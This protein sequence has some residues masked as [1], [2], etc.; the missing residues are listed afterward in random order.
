MAI[1]AK[2]Y[3]HDPSALELDGEARR[4]LGRYLRN[5]ETDPPTGAAIRDGEATAGQKSSRF[6]FLGDMYLREQEGGE[7]QF[8]RVSGECVMFKFQGI[9]YWIYTWMP[10]QT[11]ENADAMNLVAA[12]FK[13]I[14]GRVGLLGDRAEWKQQGQRRTVFAGKSADYQLVDRMGRWQV[15]ANED[16][17]ERDDKADMVLFAP[18]P[19]ARNIIERLQTSKVL[20]VLIIPGAA[21]GIG[22][23][24][25]YLLQRYQKE[26]DKATMEPADEGMQPAALA[27]DSNGKMMQWKMSIPQGRSTYVVAAVAP[28]DKDLVVAFAE[29]DWNERNANEVLFQSIVGS[30]QKKTE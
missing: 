28:R 23:A 6:V 27:N 3:D 30:L 8:E 21:D 16:P 9:G 19:T 10:L 25:Q 14:R 1:D 7:K 12:Q 29:C 2:K 20:T 13:E 5:L 24:Q 17:K 18:S 22:A 26:S 11:T 15:F 4:K